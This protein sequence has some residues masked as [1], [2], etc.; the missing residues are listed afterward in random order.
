MQ[1][2]LAAV[3]VIALV[4]VLVPLGTACGALSAMIVEWFFPVLMQKLAYMAGFARPWEL[5]AALGF[6][7]AFFR[8]STYTAKS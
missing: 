2:A 7:G 6:V 3:A 1:V 4:F 8:S 5:G